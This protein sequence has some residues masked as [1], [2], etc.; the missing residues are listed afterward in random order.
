MRKDPADLNAK[1][2]EKTVEKEMIV[3]CLLFL[4]SLSNYSVSCAEVDYPLYEI[5]SG[6]NHMEVETEKDYHIRINDQGV[7]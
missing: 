4:A 1:L 7:I 2:K 6:L 5:E 3:I